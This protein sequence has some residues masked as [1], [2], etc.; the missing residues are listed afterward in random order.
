MGKRHFVSVLRRNKKYKLLMEDI[1]SVFVFDKR[2][3]PKLPVFDSELEI[4]KSDEETQ[5][6]ESL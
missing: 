1:S 4:K 5:M 6:D 3:L 2:K